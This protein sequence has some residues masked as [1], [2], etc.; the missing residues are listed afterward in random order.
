VSERSTAR[1]LPSGD[2]A[3]ALGFVLAAAV[4]FA[5]RG[6]DRL[7]L[8]LAG[9][10]L[11][12]V[13]VV[14]RTRPLL[15]VSVFTVATCLAIVVREELAGGAG[16]SSGAFVAIFA[17]VVI[18]YSLGAH[19][20]RR[21][22]LAG[23][24][25]PVVVVVLEDLI[26]PSGDSL[27]GG[28][29]FFSL[30]VVALPVAAGRLV[31]SRRHLVARL[32]RQEEQ[33]AVT[34]HDR[35]AAARTTEALRLSRSLDSL[36]SSGLERLEV[37]ARG[38]D[39]ADAGTVELEARELLARTRHVVVEL[40][41]PARTPVGSARPV[42]RPEPDPVSVR[43]ALGTVVVAWVVVA[44]LSRLVLPLGGSIASVVVTVALAFAS[45]GLVRLP[46]A[47]VGL[48]ACLAGVVAAFGV[49][50]SLGAGAFAV[51]AWLA[52]QLVGSQARLAARVGRG[53]AELET[54]RRD[55]LLRARLEE[56]ASTAHEVHD[57][58]GHALTAIT[59]QAE[60]ARRLVEA[61]PERSS[62]V[63]ATVGR[64]AASA[65]A[66]LRTGFVG[67]SGVAQLVEGARAAGLRLDVR[68]DEAAVPEAL[69]RVVYRVLQEALTNALRHAPGATVEVWWCAAGD[70]ALVV[71]NG[72]GRGPG[73][74]GSAV[75]LDGMRRR[76]EDVGG[77]LTWWRQP[78][79]GF[80]LRADFAGVPA[81]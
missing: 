29:L 16:E 74:P 4:E 37:L 23:C 19:G 30:L 58:I 79:G 38:G 69:R 59:L 21:Q 26:E 52:G 17:L 72:P 78:D 12:L 41:Q 5:L 34:H 31:R 40:N 65:R 22:L 75:G 53:T 1:L 44:A 81:R 28:V 48:G 71:R 46:L 61:D 33:L 60:A 39:P 68:L 18:M 77:R 64:V 36:L 57:S 67:G 10:S 14:R 54:W 9:S 42:L 73:E 35:L 11:M 27:A 6:E 15:A 70:S 2:T 50:G 63:L 32:R 8:A 47:A 7:W 25:Q 66:E 62:E 3:V 49:E 56:R 55:E 80:E 43:V 76:V 51:L 13:L 20:D 45:G 24:W